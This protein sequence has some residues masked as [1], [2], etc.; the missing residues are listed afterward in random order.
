MLKRSLAAIAVISI[1]AV[2]GM[3]WAAS[4][5]APEIRIPYE[6]VFPES[7]TSTPDGTVYI[8]SASTGI[9]F[10]V[11]PGS[12]TATAWILPSSGATGILG[13]FAD[14]RSKTL[15]A[16]SLGSPPMLRAYDLGT[17]LQ[18]AQYAMPANGTCNDIAI[19]RDGTVYATDTPNMQVVRLRRG[20][21][22]LE[23]WA[24]DGFGPKGGIL[25]GIAVLGDRVL[26]NVLATSK[27]FS[28]PIGPKGKAGPITEVKLDAPIDRPDGMRSFGTKALLV[29]EGG[30]GGRMSM[31]VLSGDTGKRTVLKEGFP[32]GA[33]AVTAVGQ[34]A[35]LLEGQITAMRST[36]PNVRLKP[37]KATAVSVGSPP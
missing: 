17:G 18:K 16:C 7:L 15:W 10:R 20:A 31:V 6:R 11:R 27:L 22:A 2:P 29:A 4:G 8:G 35:W 37:F 24:A 34:T 5:P 3:T 28:V 19:G 9:I 32:D 30:S 26:A 25:D 12:D 23:V 33:V 1:L 13:V 14:A 21:Q 36:D